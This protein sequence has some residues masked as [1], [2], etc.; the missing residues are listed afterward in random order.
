MKIVKKLIL[1]LF[2]LLLCPIFVNAAS[3]TVKVSGSTTAVVGNQVKVTVTLAS[4]TPIGSWKLNLNYD[5]A[6]LSLVDSSAEAGGTIMANSSSGT[7][8]K[9]YT[10]T[11]KALKSGTTKVAATCPC[12]ARPAPWAR[13]HI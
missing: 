9:S 7:K 8:S 11:F 12:P 10:F 6:Y 1:G 13:R 5:K 2:T 4:S 3:G